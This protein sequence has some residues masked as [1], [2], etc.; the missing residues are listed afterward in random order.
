MRK[1]VLLLFLLILLAASGCSGFDPR[2][3]VDFKASNSGI[4]FANSLYVNSSLDS[5]KAASLT[6][7]HIV[8]LVYKTP[9]DGI[10]I[11]IGTSPHSLSNYSKYTFFWR[12]SSNLKNRIQKKVNHLLKENKNWEQTVVVAREIGRQLEVMTNYTVTIDPEIKPFQNYDEWLDHRN[13]TSSFDYSDQPI[14]GAVMEIYL[15]KEYFAKSANNYNWYELEIRTKLVNPASGSILAESQCGSFYPYTSG[16]S[17][18]GEPDIN[19][20]LENNAAGYKSFFQKN[21][22]DLVPECIESL[23]LI[24][25]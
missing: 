1:P 9:P 12:K 20:L 23:G 13:E 14:S 22:R 4:D 2:K 19:R 25:K 24:K 15:T 10:D 17:H 8:S 11:T 21:V 18:Y 3:T 6:N 7:I 16:L 5:D